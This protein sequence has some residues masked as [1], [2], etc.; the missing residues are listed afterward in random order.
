MVSNWLTST[1]T[2]NAQPP[3]EFLSDWLDSQLSA[4][5]SSAS[6]YYFPHNKQSCS[7]LTIK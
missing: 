4:V 7:T 2:C 3:S 6:E 1:E 5:T